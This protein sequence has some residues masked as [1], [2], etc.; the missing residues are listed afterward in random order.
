MKLLGQI[1]AGF[2]RFWYDFL[3]GDCWQLALGVACI[4]GGLAAALHAGLLSHVQPHP[5]L[6]I[7]AGAALMLLVVLV[8]LIE[9]KAKNKE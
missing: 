6:P 2:F 9:F 1:V 3:I 4:M 8:V 7:T 5:W